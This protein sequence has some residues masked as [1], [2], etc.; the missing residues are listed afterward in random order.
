MLGTHIDRY[1]PRV[2][3]LITKNGTL[4]LGPGD[5]KKRNTHTREREKRGKGIPSL[6]IPRLP[7]FHPMSFRPFPVMLQTQWTQA[8]SFRNYIIIAWKEAQCT[9]S[10]TGKP[11]ARGDSCKFHLLHPSCF[12]LLFKKTRTVLT[13]NGNEKKIQIGFN[14]KDSRR[15][16][17][18]LFLPRRPSP[19]LTKQEKKIEKK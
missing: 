15:T 3:L 8:A 11:P 6:G 7:F 14:L 5:K 16:L 13:K 10:S 9:Y 18:I 17:F 4:K 2:F 1:K 19:Y 12:H